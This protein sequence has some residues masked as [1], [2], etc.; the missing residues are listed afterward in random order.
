MTESIESQNDYDIL[1]DDYIGDEFVHIKN[2]KTQTQTH[3]QEI[4]FNTPSVLPRG[5]L[6]E[7]SSY[8]E[9]T[10]Q[11]KKYLPFEDFVILLHEEL[12][13]KFGHKGFSTYSVPHKFS[14]IIRSYLH[15]K[16]HK[17][18][19]RMFIEDDGEQDEIYLNGSS[20]HI[21]QKENLHTSNN[22]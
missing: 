19:K 20:T 4:N 16:V 6:L 2:K 21:Y 8:D 9:L 22:K 12:Q 13:E 11:E 15:V 10:S 14:N 7:K 3:M 1:N 5:R 17:K 18:P